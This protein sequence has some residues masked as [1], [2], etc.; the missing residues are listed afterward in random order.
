MVLRS[1]T[2]DF[3]HLHTLLNNQHIKKLTKVVA[4]LTV[5]DNY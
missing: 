4:L 2:T 3:F 1:Q 5:V